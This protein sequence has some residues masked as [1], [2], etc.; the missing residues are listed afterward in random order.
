[1]HR[2]RPSGGCDLDREGKLVPD[3]MRGFGHPGSL[4]YCCRHFRMRQ[5]LEA[6]TTELRRWR[7][8]G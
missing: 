2:P 4:G 7:V 6:T 1:M 3:G 5:F 8:A